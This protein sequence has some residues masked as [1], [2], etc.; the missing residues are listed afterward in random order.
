MKS[1]KKINNLIGQVER[2][3]EEYDDI[4]ILLVGYTSQDIVEQVKEQVSNIQKG[5]RSSLQQQRIKIIKK[6][7]RK[8][9]KEK[10]QDKI[11]QPS[12]YGYSLPKFEPP[13]FK[14]PKYEPPN[15]D[16]KY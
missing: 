15:F 16:F 14:P 11:N 4:I 7:T 10:K 12:G 6:D 3:K 5:Q 2:H 1:R 8:S 9:S 13:K